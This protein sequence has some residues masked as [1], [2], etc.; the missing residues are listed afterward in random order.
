MV[1]KKLSVCIEQPTLTTYTTQVVPM[2][3]GSGS[4]KII[5]EENQASRQV[6]LSQ[7]KKRDQFVFWLGGIF[8]RST[9]V[10]VSYFILNGVLGMLRSPHFYFFAKI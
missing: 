4:L 6:V 1:N 10:H 2:I 7:Q 5:F 8:P 3:Y 9:Q